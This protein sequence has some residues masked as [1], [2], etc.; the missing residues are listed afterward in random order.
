MY[1]PPSTNISEF[2]KTFNTQI[3]KINTKEYE[4]II[5][6]NHNLDF[7]KQSVHLKTQEFL[8][9]I[10]DHNLLPTV[11]KPTRISKTSATLID[12][13][14]ISKKL[15]SDYESLIIVDDLSDHLPCLVKLK[16]F[17]PTELKTLLARGFLIIRQ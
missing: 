2:I 6:L 14:L 5:G 17:Q 7:L 4:W 15:Q 8:E 12:N 13:I 1:R 10:L 11:T 3:G 9:C 16:N